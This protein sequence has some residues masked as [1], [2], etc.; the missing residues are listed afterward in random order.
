MRC[1]KTQPRR[2]QQQASGPG[3]SHEWKLL[4]KSGEPEFRENDWVEPVAA[5]AGEL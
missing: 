4:K 2:N 1:I 5:Q 3:C